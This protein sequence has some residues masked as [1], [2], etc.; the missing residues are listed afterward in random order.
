MT[1]RTLL[2]SQGDEKAE[3]MV[4]IPKKCVLALLIYCNI[5]MPW[6]GFSSSELLL[7]AIDSLLDLLFMYLDEFHKHDQALK[8]KQKTNSARA[9]KPVS[10]LSFRMIW[11]PG[12]APVKSL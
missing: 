3:K 8:R 4:K 5:Q 2:F 11:K 1:K 9:T 6:C 12:S 7:E 10:F